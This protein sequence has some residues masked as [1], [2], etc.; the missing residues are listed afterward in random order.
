MGSGTLLQRVFS[1]GSLLS[2]EPCGNSHSILGGQG[3]KGGFSRFTSLSFFRGLHTSVL[4]AADEGGA[5]RGGAKGGGGW[6]L[7]GETPS[8]SSFPPSSPS[9][10]VS[11]PEPSPALKAWSIPEP[12][13]WALAELGIVTPSEIQ[14][15]A[16]RALLS[17]VGSDGSAE[18]GR[19]HNVLLASHTGSGKTLAYLLPICERLKR[20]EASGGAFS[21]PRR[22]RALIVLPTKELSEQVRDV[23]KR[24]SHWVKLRGASIGTGSARS[25]RERLEAAPDVVVGTPSALLA[26]HSRGRLFFGDV[27]EI[28]LDEFDALLDP[29]G[30]F[31]E[32]VE[33]IL[34]AAR[35]I[36]NN[37][38]HRRKSSADGR[39][40]DGRSADGR[41]SGYSQ[42]DA[43]GQPSPSPPP[44]SSPCGPA[45]CRATLVGASLPSAA[46][47]EAAR[48]FAG[49]GKLLERSTTSTL[50]RGVPASRHRFVDVPP[51][52]DRLV[53][54]VD[55]VEKLHQEK[56][57]VLVFAN[58]LASCRACAWAVEERGVPCV[59]LHGGIGPAQR[60]QTIAR[61]RGGR[62]KGAGSETEA[63][64]AKAAERDADG[65]EG[66]DPEGDWKGEG[67]EDEM[68]DD[69]ALETWEKSR[70]AR[71]EEWEREQRS[72][73]EGEASWNGS[74]SSEPPRDA[75]DGSAL[76]SSSASSP[77]SPPSSRA[78][79]LA[80]ASTPPILVCTDLAARGLDF[81]AVDAVVNFDFPLSG[82]EYLHRAGRTARAGREG[83]VVSLVAKRDRV[84]AGK[85]RDALRSGD[86]IHALDGRKDQHHRPDVP[87]EGVVRYK[88]DGQAAG[89]AREDRKKEGNNKRG[90][91]GKRHGDE[92][93]PA[94]GGGRGGQARSRGRVPRVKP[95]PKGFKP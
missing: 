32:D 35:A 59:S 62:W 86:D 84:L 38:T 58:T 44:S 60:L 31:S 23:L 43:R 15:E 61:L 11:F 76:G 49:P 8:S 69:K 2:A 57:R 46:R 55:F 5:D 6:D 1:R 68:E 14:V 34:R 65:A 81:P 27:C 41:R 37:E 67:W 91:K 7:R 47:R 45:A 79:S 53:R 52:D 75:Q 24:L 73:T 94:P 71:E 36:P 54:L 93:K 87:V 20:Q 78:S 80:S 50:H 72:W 19:I 13:R 64:A 51:S 39:G 22:P 25:R 17:G 92:A 9:S 10:S 63:G 90:S 89:K 33:T 70:A 66:E 77:I 40:A 29:S 74:A 21:R 12:S 42:R 48:L 83:L 3:G 28:V 95:R 16:R 4:A 18:A 88:A 56:K 85:I 82:V 26:E 30:G